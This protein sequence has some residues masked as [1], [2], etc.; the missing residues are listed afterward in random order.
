M[1]FYTVNQLHVH[2]H[3]YM[4]KTTQLEKC[5]YIYMINQS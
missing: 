4:Y 3:V 1:K 2:V 5:M